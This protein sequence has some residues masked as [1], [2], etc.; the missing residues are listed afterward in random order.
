MKFKIIPLGILLLSLFLV[1][2]QQ[3][4][5]VTKGK[6]SRK[7]IHWQDIKRTYL[8]YIPTSYDITKPMPL[9]F[10][11]H[12]GGGTAWGTMRLTRSRFNEL[13]DEK[14]FIVVYP[15]AVK[16]N[17][18]DGRLSNLKPG[19]EF[20]DDVGFITQIVEKMKEEYNIDNQRVFTTGM[21]NG[22]F[23]SSRLLC[24]RSDIFRGGAIVTAT[25]SIDYINSCIPE[26]PVG[27][28]VMNGT[29]DPLVPYEGG[30]VMVFNKERGEIVSTDDYVEYWQ[31]LLGSSGT[32]Y[33]DNLPD[34]NS[35]DNS[36][37][38]VT[39]YTDCDK[40]AALKLYK[41][42]GGGHTWPGG[43][44][45]LSKKLIGSTNYDINACDVIWEFFEELPD[46]E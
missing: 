17:W 32:S 19:M 33:T 39:T 42:E 31:T 43:R 44:Q 41:I 27:V 3:S 21:S 16:K 24:D 6:I 18:N 38:S 10:D 45:Y 15:N 37:V 28:L 20:I 34:K 40:D 30:Q 25:L 29:D 7:V 12:G 4:T 46:R 23:M 11:I 14:G 1:S 26:N 36:T 22:G 2:F 13:A 35:E 9:L 8:V 5:T